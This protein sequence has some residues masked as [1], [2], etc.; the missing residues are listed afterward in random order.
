MSFPDFN[1]SFDFQPNMD[2]LALDLA[3]SVLHIS[4]SEFR[5]M[6]DADLKKYYTIVNNT[7]R[8]AYQ[9][10]LSYKTKYHNTFA[11]VRVKYTDDKPMLR[12][13]GNFTGW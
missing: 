7:E 11:P 5:S 1:P 3:L 10:L 9:V 4:R 8:F 12:I 13:Q 6:S 2:E